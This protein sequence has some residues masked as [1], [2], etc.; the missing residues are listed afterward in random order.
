[1]SSLSETFE[2]PGQRDTQKIF[3]A[4]FAFFEPLR[5][6]SIKFQISN[7]KFQIITCPKS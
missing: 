3:F 6:T 2:P 1:M 5:E 7:L 4:D